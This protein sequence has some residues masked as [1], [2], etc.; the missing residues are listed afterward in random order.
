MPLEPC[1]LSLVMAVADNL[2]IGLDGKLPWRSPIDLGRFKE[3]TISGAVVMGRKTADSLKGPLSKRVNVV[4]TRSREYQ[5]HGFYSANTPEDALSLASGT[6]SGVFVI[7]GAEIFKLYVAQ[8]DRIYVSK[9][10]GHP[11][12]DT[13]LTDDFFDGWGTVPDNNWSG[14]EVDENGFFKRYVLRRV[15]EMS[16]L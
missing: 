6:K 7:G 16:G 5:R 10:F 15:E 3:L 12:A 11:E 4:L 14:S 13:F 8:A 1:R 2:G 9:F